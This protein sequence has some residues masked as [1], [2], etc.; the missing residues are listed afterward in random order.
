[1]LKFDDVLNDQRHVT[2]SQ[3]K[4]VMQSLNSYEFGDSFINSTIDDLVEFQKT[5]TDIEKKILSTLG[6]MFKND[7][8]QIQSHLIKNLGIK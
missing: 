7:E 1:M 3:R 6:G 5:N 2:F 8:I 4:K